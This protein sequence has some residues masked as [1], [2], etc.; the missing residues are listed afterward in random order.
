MLL[1]GCIWDDPGPGQ[2]LAVGLLNDEQVELTVNPCDDGLG[3]LSVTL[4]HSRGSVG[5]PDDDILWMVESDNGSQERNYVLGVVP[6][7]FVETHPFEEIAAD[8]PLAIE[9]RLVDKDIPLR[10]GFQL[11]DLR[12]DSLLIDGDMFIDRES[13][14]RRDTCVFDA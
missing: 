11:S 14:S 8:T 1:N 10:L 4:L 7:E 6:S 2:E 5:R 9:V 12:P 13:Y 3:V